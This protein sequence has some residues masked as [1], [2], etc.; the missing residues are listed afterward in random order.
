MAIFHSYVQWNQRL[1]DE[2]NHA[3]VLGETKTLMRSSVQDGATLQSPYVF[4]MA[5]STASRR[6]FLWAPQLGNGVVRV[7]RGGCNEWV[8]RAGH[9]GRELRIEN[10]YPFG[11]Q[12]WTVMENHGAQNW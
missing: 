9:R 6:V 2:L 11:I 10:G 1:V 8:G 12:T 4:L 3:F 7:G 5:L